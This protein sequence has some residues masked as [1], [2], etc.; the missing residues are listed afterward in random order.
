MFY[1]KIDINADVGESFGNYKYG[2]D[3]ELMPYLTSANVACGFHAGD[4][5]VMR[6]TV[7]LA[8]RH[9]VAVGAH[10]GF[11]DLLGFGRRMM[12][13]SAEEMR[14][15]LIYQV[16]ALK[17]FLELEGMKLHH[18]GPHGSFSA[19]AIRNEDVAEAIVEAI[20]QIDPEIILV[21]RPGLAPYE[22]ARAKGLRVAS[23]IGV[24]IDYR[25][26]RTAIIQK[27]KKSMDVQE[28]VRRVRKI[29][30][31]GKI[32]ASDGSEMQFRIDTL[33]VH[34]DTPN[35]IE[36]CTAVR[37]ELEVMGV[38]VTCFSHFV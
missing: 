26:D 32:E 38:E 14:D 1:S 2:R 9:G 35:V 5:S 22:I 4:P 23:Q 25:P 13:V 17:A 34:G 6:K 3:A 18:I 30:Q 8:K 33:L 24:D 11:P 10:P 20:F 12:D 28:A 29:I 7:Q 15:Y 36:I 21:G 27:E 16:G 19:H 37:S 31:D